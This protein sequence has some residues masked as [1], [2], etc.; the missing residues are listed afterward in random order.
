[1]EIKEE[2]VVVS[3]S[4]KWESIELIL[5]GTAPLFLGGR[6]GLRLRL[7]QTSESSCN[8]SQDYNY[9]KNN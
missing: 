2:P 7:E 4:A 9:Y 1:M 3:T 8:F 5:Q 6:S